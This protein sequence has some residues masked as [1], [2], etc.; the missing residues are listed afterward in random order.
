MA[1]INK[2]ASFKSFSEIIAQEK[3]V[4]ETQINAAKRGQLSSKIATLLDEMN[5]TSFEGLD[6]KVREEFIKKVF[7]EIV[8][9]DSNGIMEGTRSQFGKIDKA[10]NITSVYIHYDGYPENMLPIIQKGYKA[11]KG[12]DTVIAGGS[13]AG[14]NQ[15]PRSMDYYGKSTDL[16][17]LTGSIKRISKYLKDAN[18]ESSAEFVYLW[19]ETSNT[20]MMADIYNNKGLVPAFESMLNEKLSPEQRMVETFLKKVAK[21]FDYSIEDAARFVKD[22]I[23]KMGLNESMNE[24]IDIYDRLGDLMKNLNTE[25]GNLKG[26]TKDTQWLKQLDLIQSALEKLEDRV[27]IATKKLGVISESMN[28]SFE[29]HYSDGIRSMKK[30]GNEKQAIT[31][32]K[33]LIK[34]KSGLQFVDVFKA[35]SGFHSTADTSAIVAFWGDGSYTDNVAKKDDKLAAKK[36]NEAEVNEG[37]GTIALGI[38]LAWVGLRVIGA[39][40]KKVLGKIGANVEIAPEQL[41]QI[42]NDLALRVAKETGSGQSVLLGT[43]LKIELDKKIDSGEIKTV[44]ALEKAM[45]EYLSTNESVVNEDSK[46]NYVTITNDLFHADSN[47][48]VKNKI[49]VSDSISKALDGCKTKHVV[50]NIDKIHESVMNEAEVKSDEEFKEYAFTVLK[51]AFGEEFD[52]AK[53]QEVVDGILGKVDGD[54]G[55][56]VGMLT[57]SLG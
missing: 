53:A 16:V 46:I 4:K 45:E 40:A 21:E 32:A 38:M 26:S 54:Y 13:A 55:A 12:V 50:I 5:I 34:N 30:F 57:S 35:G 20:W 52:E 22:T 47:W 9:D 28:E 49:K 48:W 3:A 36:I 6:Q 24:E 29:V 27:S 37:V 10:G 43:F 39:V 33:D 31:F 8:E 14:L 56:A 11:G 17:P 15:N 7:G 41:K 18:D 44:N 2:I 51:K 19:D 1:Q 23:S 42:T 25:I